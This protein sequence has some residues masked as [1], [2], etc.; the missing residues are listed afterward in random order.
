MGCQCTGGDVNKYLACGQQIARVIDPNDVQS[1]AQRSGATG[2]DQLCYVKACM[3]VG[4]VIYW[5]NTPGDCPTPTKLDASAAQQITKA[6]GVGLTGVG[7]ASAVGLLATGG[8]GIGGSAAG[9]GA[10]LGGLPAV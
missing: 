6:V 7:A 5:K 10:S 4:R 9:A 2:D 1:Y 8:A 3:I